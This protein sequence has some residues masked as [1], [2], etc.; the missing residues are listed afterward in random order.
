MKFKVG[1]KI[2]VVHAIDKEVEELIGRV[3]KIRD[4][5]EYDDDYYSVEL[6][7]GDWIELFEEELEII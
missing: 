5:A 6:E 1:D 2:R 7:N 3:G 4:I